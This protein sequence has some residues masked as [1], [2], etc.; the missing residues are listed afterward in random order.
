MWTVHRALGA[1]AIALL[2]MA[3]FPAFAQQSPANP[4]KPVTPATP[5]DP[6]ANFTM[7]QVEGGLM[8]LDTRTGKLS[9][10]S[11]R[12]SAWTCELVPEERSAYEEEI[13]RLNGR[14]ATLERGNVPPGVPDIAKPPAAGTPPVAGTPPA[15]TPKAGEGSGDTA[16][17]KP[18]AGD[19][20][21][22]DDVRG[23]MD[24]AMDMAEQVFR[25]FLEMV[26]RLK[27]ETEKL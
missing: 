6:Q 11:T 10:C 16:A 18:D 13:G 14:I 1:A 2:A 12:T 4:T 15:V 27:G 20:T 25:R 17:K 24:R 26:E 8:K 23:H 19:S 5:V 21:D 3:A 22:E 7:L 9:F